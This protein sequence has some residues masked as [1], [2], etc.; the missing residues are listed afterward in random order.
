MSEIAIKKTPI[1]VKVH[2]VGDKKCNKKEM[3]K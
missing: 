1:L 2:S 3:K